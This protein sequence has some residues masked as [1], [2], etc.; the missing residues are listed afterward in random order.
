MSLFSQGIP[1]ES[2]SA[3]AL[4]RCN[5]LAKDELEAAHKS[6]YRK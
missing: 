1:R 2:L 5:A 3:L 4:V 6:I